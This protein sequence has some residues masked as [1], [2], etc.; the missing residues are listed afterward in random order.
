MPWRRRD[1]LQVGGLGALGLSA[2]DLLAADSTKATAKSCILFF[3]EGGP[4]QIDMWDMKPKAP[5]TIRGPLQPIDTT[6][7]GYQVCEHLPQLATQMRHF[8]VCLLYTSPR[9]RD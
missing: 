9:P 8:S 1:V 7:P 2:P 4:S 3:M 5:E 6:I